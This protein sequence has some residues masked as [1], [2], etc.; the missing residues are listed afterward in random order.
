MWDPRLQHT[1]VLEE[2][3]QIQT[4]SLR[5]S[6]GSLDN[7]GHFRSSVI[8]TRHISDEDTLDSSNPADVI[9]KIIISSSQYLK[10]IPIY[11]SRTAISDSSTYSSCY[12]LDPSY[13]AT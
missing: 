12:S 10:L 4:I 6:W 2:A 11:D 13:C 5:Q 3:F 1:Y 9:S 8:G 7:E